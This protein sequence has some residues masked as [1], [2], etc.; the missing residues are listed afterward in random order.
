VH[1]QRDEV[2][3]LTMTPPVVSAATHVRDRTAEL[4]N[5]AERHPFQR[6]L[7]SGRLSLTTFA[8]QLSQLYLVHRQLERHLADHLTATPSIRAVVQ[9]YHFRADLMRSDLEAMGLDA[10]GTPRLPATEALLQEMRRDSESVP[11]RLLGYLYVL[12]GATNGTRILRPMLL[13]RYPQLGPD[14]LASFDPHG[15]LH[16]QRWQRFRRD[17]SGLDWPN[18]ALDGLA[19]AAAA[20]FRAVIG[21]MDMLIGPASGAPRRLAEDPSRLANGVQFAN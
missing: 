12:E 20:V 2:G 1:L 10:D 15:T 21:I 16:P 3:V 9:G 7:I 13:S 18:E 19:Q 6:E 17:L 11:A 14:G 4:H 8:A 5:R